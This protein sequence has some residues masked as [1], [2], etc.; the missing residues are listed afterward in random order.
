MFH[1]IALPAENKREELSPANGKK[2]NSAL[3]LSPRRRIFYAPALSAEKSY[4]LSKKKISS[5][6]N[7]KNM[8]LSSQ[9]KLSPLENKRKP[10]IS[11][12]RHTLLRTVKHNRKINYSN[13]LKNIK[14]FIQP[15]GFL[16]FFL[17]KTF[18]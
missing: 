2:I 11:P 18:F 9:N 8:N 4:I 7:Q 5:R 13:F 1:G 12:P 3:I 16:L 14:N 17:K 15:I 10:N 6:E